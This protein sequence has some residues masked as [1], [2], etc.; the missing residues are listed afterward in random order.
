MCLLASEETTA[1]RY[2]DAVAKVNHKGWPVTN[3]DINDFASNFEFEVCNEPVVPTVSGL[4]VSKSGDTITASWDF[5]AGCVS[6][7][8]ADV[9]FG[10]E[11]RV[12]GLF[13][14]LIEFSD[15]SSC[16]GNGN[17]LTCTYDYSYVP[18]GTFIVGVSIFVIPVEKKY[19]GNDYGGEGTRGRR[20]MA[21]VG[22]IEF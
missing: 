20:Y 14:S 8:L 2:F 15:T 19:G 6:I 1:N 11:W 3:A 16:G 5:E 4:A 17:R 9:A 12:L 22:P 10:V 13:S 7:A 21:N 18:D